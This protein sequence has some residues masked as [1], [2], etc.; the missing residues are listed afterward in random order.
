MAFVQAFAMVGEHLDNAASPDM[1][2]CALRDHRP[3]ILPQGGQARDPVVDVGK[4]L[5]RDG[6]GPDAGT[7]G[8]ARPVRAGPG[9]YR[10]RS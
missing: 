4:V 5:A 2:A 9:S 6:I 8:D 3:H 7:V 10:L 1:A